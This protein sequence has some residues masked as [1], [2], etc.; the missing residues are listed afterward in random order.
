MSDNRLIGAWRLLSAE[1]HSSDGKVIYPWGKNATGIL[2]YSDTGYVSAQIMNPDRL[3]FA[4]CDNLKGTPAETKVA[5]DGYQAYF[6]TF[7]LTEGE[8]TVIHHITGNLFPNAIGIDLKRYYEISGDNRLILS[9]PPMTLNGERVTGV[10]V[11]DRLTRY[12]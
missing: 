9:T 4:S 7:E 8:K 6:G 12:D 2:V 5:F 10:L 11:W 3:E 1:F